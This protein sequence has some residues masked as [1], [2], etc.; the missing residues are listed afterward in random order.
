MTGAVR[1]LGERSTAL[2]EGLGQITRFGGS[3]VAAFTCQ[4]NT[5]AS[6]CHRRTRSV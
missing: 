2:V 1:E 4:R 5:V 3:L 6:G